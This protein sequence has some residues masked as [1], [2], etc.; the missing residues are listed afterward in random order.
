MQRIR[1]LIAETDETGFHLV[2][3]VHRG[4]AGPVIQ[5]N[6]A[7]IIERAETIH[8][9][10]RINFRAEA[11]SRRAGNELSATTA[12]RAGTADFADGPSCPRLFAAIL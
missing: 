11:A 5:S 6:R 3:E 4:R 2:D 9:S 10:S 12:S 7:A 8:H 1:A